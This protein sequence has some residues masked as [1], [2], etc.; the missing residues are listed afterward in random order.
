VRNVCRRESEE[1]N[2][3]SLKI[4]CGKL[5]VTVTKG[6]KNEKPDVGEQGLKRD[7]KGLK[8]RKIFE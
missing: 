5:N 7:E 2:M 6:R 1:I 4:K 3:R 8:D